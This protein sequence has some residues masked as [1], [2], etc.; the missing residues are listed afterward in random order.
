MIMTSIQTII[1]THDC[2]EKLSYLTLNIKSA[3]KVIQ[4]ILRLYYAKKHT[5]ILVEISGL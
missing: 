1:T 5:V 4:I 2:F 3:C